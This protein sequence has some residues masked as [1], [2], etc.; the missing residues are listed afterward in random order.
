MHGAAL[1]CMSSSCGHHSLCASLSTFL[2]ENLREQLET[3]VL[4]AISVY[5][6]VCYTHR[7]I[8]QALQRMHLSLQPKPS[9][10]VLIWPSLHT[11]A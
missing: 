5:V 9:L 10:N 11:V 1:L 3:V 6:T 8:W 7:H 2:G 4:K